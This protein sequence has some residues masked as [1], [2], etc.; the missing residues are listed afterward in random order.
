MAVYDCFTFFNELELLDL[1][2]YLLNNVVDY[3]VI[4]EMNKT[5]RGKDKEYIFE[6]NKD[7]YEKYI[8]KI[9]YIKIEDVPKYDDTIYV[10]EENNIIA[11]DWTLEFF[12]RNA[13]IKGLKKCKPSD[14]IMISDI[15]E[16]PSP[17]V[18][19]DILNKSV[20]IKRK[21]HLR[22]K[23]KLVKRLFK[24]NPFYLFKNLKVKD[25]IDL[26]PISLEQD[27]YY[28]YLNG[29]L[30]NKWYGT[31]ICKYKNLKSPQ[32][33][34][35][36]R[37]K[38]L[39]IKNGG[40]HFSYLG[41]V[42]RIIRKMMSIVEGNDEKAKEVHIKNCIEK[43]KDIYGKKHVKINYINKEEIG[44]KNIDKYIKKYPY[45]YKNRTEKLE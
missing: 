1:R 4:V 18:L 8:N 39:T 23:I 7:K 45:L 30:N 35:N 3:F 28:Y 32:E 42:D 34:R 15:D 2:L 37:N 27:M 16:I 24:I 12:Q 14:I 41:G 25:I 33:M 38:M 40:W 11:R 19:D 43:G 44:I 5:F 29:K 13:I 9:V 17:L 22:A 26:M 10:K 6:K 21:K 31:V 36:N 20:Y